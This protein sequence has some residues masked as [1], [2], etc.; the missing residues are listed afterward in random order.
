M[1]DNRIC[2]NE[3]QYVYES[4]KQVLNNN[5]LSQEE[6]DD[7]L[8]ELSYGLQDLIDS[9]SCDYV[10]RK[11]LQNYIYSQS[12]MNREALEKECL[13]MKKIIDD[14]QYRP[15][16]TPLF[17]TFRAINKLFGDLYTLEALGRKRFLSRPINI[18]ANGKQAK[19][20]CVYNEGSII[21]NSS[22]EAYI[23]TDYDMLRNV[24]NS[25]HI[26]PKQFK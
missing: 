8:K 20:V 25:K 1:D 17:P 23:E 2:K 3:K 5:I 6:K 10:D 7:E 19:I 22:F 15:S 24:P 21:N 14:L 12:G 4:V 11:E 18:G 9:G 26:V 13:N 16:N